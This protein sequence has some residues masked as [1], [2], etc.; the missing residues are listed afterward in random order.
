MKSQKLAQDKDKAAEE[1]VKQLQKQIEHHDNKQD[2][3]QPCQATGVNLFA[4][5]ETVHGNT[6]GAEL[7]AKAQVAMAA[8]HGVKRQRED[9]AES[10]GKSVHSHASHNSCKVKHK[11]L[12]SGISVKS[13]QKVRYEV[14]WAHHWLGKEYDA[15]P[16]SFNQMRVAIT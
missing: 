3:Q 9:D 10:E 5:L 8:A 6:V 2:N 12:Q 1:Q 15:N 11:K 13:G 16:V 4:N 7:A 14:E